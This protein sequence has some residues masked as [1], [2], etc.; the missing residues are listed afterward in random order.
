M[1]CR[2]CKKPISITH[3][4]VDKEFCSRQHRTAFSAR[5]AR[6]LREMGEFTYSVADVLRDTDEF[7]I[8]KKKAPVSGTRSTATVLGLAALTIAGLVILEKTGMG[9][10]PQGKATKADARQGTVSQL[11]GMVID[12]MPKTASGG[13]VIEDRFQTGLRNWLPAPGTGLSGWRLEN[14]LMKPGGLRIWDES[15]N[16]GD[17]S[18]QFEGRVESKSLGWVVRAPNHNNYYAAKLSIPDRGGAV[19]PEIIRFSVIQGQESRR[20]HFPIPVQIDKDEFYSYEVRAVGDRILTIIGGRVVDQWRDARFRTGG[21]GFFSE[22]GDKS[23]VRWAK[24]QEGESIAD[25]LRSYLTFGLIIP[26]L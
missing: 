24:L 16:L 21:V 20:Q 19:R 18:F 5:S 12:R 1:V 7:A 3:R 6:A 9:G 8:P 14:G 11:V 22:R 10:A 23:S 13:L 15:R 17:Y 26:V 2:Y 25:K 4:L